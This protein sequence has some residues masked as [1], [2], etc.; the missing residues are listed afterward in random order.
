MSV[1]AILDSPNVQI[2]SGAMSASTGRSS[3]CLMSMISI[4]YNTIL[5]P[6][7]VAGTERITTGIS[8]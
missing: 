4:M 2:I 3:G 6:S 1:Y 8:G 5:L 7:M